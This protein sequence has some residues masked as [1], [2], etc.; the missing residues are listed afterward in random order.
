MGET[1]ASD[2][3]Y[4]VVLT[5]TDDILGRWSVD[6]TATSGVFVN[7]PELGR[8]EVAYRRAWPDESGVNSTKHMKAIISHDTHL[9][10]LPC[11]AAFINSHLSMAKCK[12]YC[13]AMGA[14]HFRWFHDGC[15]ECVGKYC[16]NYGVDEPRCLIDID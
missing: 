15:C 3:D 4:F 10:K 14:S 12:Q 9:K 5:E 2:E 8:I 6:T 16:L 7:H 11:I 1:N 13:V